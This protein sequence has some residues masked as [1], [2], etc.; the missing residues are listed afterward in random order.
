MASLDYPRRQPGGDNVIFDPVETLRQLVAIP[1]VNPMGQGVT[2]PE[3][4]EAK[5]TRPSGIGVCRAWGFR[6]GANRYEPGRANL[7]ARLDGE[8]SCERGGAARSFWAP[9]K[10]RFRWAG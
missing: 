10:I 8:V 4:G 6:T 5:L 3:Y 9:I 1:S 7:I 2:G